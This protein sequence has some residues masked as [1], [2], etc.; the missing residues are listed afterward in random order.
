FYDSLM[1]SY[2]LTVI[3]AAFGRGFALRVGVGDSG[4]RV[5]LTAV[6]LIVFGIA[7]R[8]M[9]YRGGVDEG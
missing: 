8:L 6:P 3:I 2:V 9:A 5:L 4:N 7:M 1:I